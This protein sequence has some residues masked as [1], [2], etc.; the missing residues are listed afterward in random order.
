MNNFTFY[1][2]TQAVFGKDQIA[3]LDSLVPSGATVLITYGGG[4]VKRFGTL[5]SVKAELAKSE[6]TVLE[7]G[8]IEA[9][10]QFSTLMNAVELAR[11]E[12]VDFL[13]ALGGGSVMDG[14]KFIALAVTADDYK[15][16]ERELMNFGFAPVPV[17]TAIPMGTV[18]TLPATGSEMNGFAVISD[19]HD[20]LPVFS[21][22]TYP[23][24]SILDPELTY[25][26]PTHQ[27]ANGVVDTFVHVLEQ[28]VTY[29][30]DARF[31]DRVA[32]GILQTL[33]EVGPTTIAEP[34]NYNARANL[35]WCATMALNGVVGSGV[36]QDWTTHMIG[37]ELTALF[38]LDH[39]RT[40]AI[41]QSPLWKLRFEKKQA[42]L[43]QYAERVWGI[44]EGT[45]SEKAETAIEKTEAFFRSLGMKTKLSENNIGESD[46]PKVVEAL[47]KHGMTQ[48]SET[49][50]FTLEDAGAVLKLAV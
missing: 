7:F 23:K 5:D 38:G 11:A 3:Q 29:P 8:G 44:S 35:F 9:N 19:G 34:E 2:P 22:L 12:K 32:E 17:D 46:I 6:R 15:G 10:P 48:L 43:A 21:M 26:L 45:E 28:Y 42:K 50:D 30:V 20:K 18:V 27:V 49:G 16:K 36:P 14:T 24:F 33:I 13:L 25:S 4:S 37:H 41:V 31:Q 47:E 40:L 1:N 39:A